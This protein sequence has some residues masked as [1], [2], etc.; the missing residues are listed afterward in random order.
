M[1]LQA[2]VNTSMIDEGGVKKLHNELQNVRR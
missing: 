1:S 2:A